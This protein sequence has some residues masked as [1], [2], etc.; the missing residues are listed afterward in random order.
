MID[1]QHTDA[2]QRCLGRA[3]RMLPCSRP[4][5]SVSCNARTACLCWAMLVTVFTMRTWGSLGG[6]RT[7]NQLAIMCVSSSSDSDGYDGGPLWSLYPTSN[8]EAVPVGWTSTPAF[9]TQTR[10]QDAALQYTGSLPLATFDH[11]RCRSS[12]TQYVRMEPLRQVS[13]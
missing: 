7:Q 13:C 4:E 6:L 2:M 3:Y 1:D 12:T 11:L 8:L 5:K 9:S 10:M